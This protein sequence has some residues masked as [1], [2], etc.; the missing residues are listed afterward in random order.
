MISKF[1][2]SLAS[3]NKII[4]FDERQFL[5]EKSSSPEKLKQYIHEGTL[6]LDSNINEEERYFLYGVLGNLHRIN[7]QPKDALDYLTM[8]LNYAEKKEDHAK[9]IVSTIRLGEAQKYNGDHLNALE[10]FNHALEKCNS[11][12]EG[13]YIDFVL[14]HKGKCLME[15]SKL[16]EAENCFL[17][18]L[19]VRL[20]KND[21]E[22][23]AST[24]K[25]LDLVQSLIRKAQT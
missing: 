22:L 3:L 21:H 18:A 19:N 14:Q 25:A 12:N 16:K 1:K 2:E 17:E 11:H 15:L 20:K 8:C 7:G 10:L 9:V 6:L 13:R 4:Y 23:L 24:Q 5:R